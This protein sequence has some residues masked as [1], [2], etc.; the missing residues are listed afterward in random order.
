MIL[1]KQKQF[2]Y[3]ILSVILISVAV[4][5]SISAWT[6]SGNTNITDDYRS[7]NIEATSIINNSNSISAAYDNLILNGANPS[8]IVYLPNVASTP[9]APN[10]L[11]PT[12]GA[13]IV[14][15]SPNAIRANGNALDGMFVLNKI[16]FRG[17]NIGTNFGADYAIIA[18]GIKDSVCAAIDKSLYG[19]N[20]MPTI[21]GLPIDSASYLGTATA[22]NPNTSVAITLSYTAAHT[23]MTGCYKTRPNVPDSNLFFKIIRVT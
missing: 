13:S 14:G 18:S 7:I 22:A 19:L 6:L 11:D 9:S 21:G 20:T 8:S 17:G 4:V 10:I 5:G 3:S 15:F 16:S 12:N 2:G 1:N 23:W